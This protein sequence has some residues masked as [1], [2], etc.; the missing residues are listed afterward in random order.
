[1]KSVSPKSAAKTKPHGPSKVGKHREEAVASENAKSDELAFAKAETEKP[2]PREDAD[3]AEGTAFKSYLEAVAEGDDS[4]E[5][6]L[7]PLILVGGALALGG[8]GAVALGGGGNKAP[9][10]VT[11]VAVAATEDTA[12]TFSISATD[13]DNDVLTYTASGA[14]KGTVTGGTGGNF[15][16]TP[17][18]N[19]NGTDTVTVTVSDG[20]K[21]ATATVN[22]TIAAVNDAPTLAAIAALTTNE[23]TAKTFTA[24][25]ADI[26]STTLTYTAAGATKGVVTGGANGAFTYTPNA[27]ANGTDTFTVT[28]SDGA[29]TATQ[30]VT[31]NITPVPDAPVV[32][33][34]Q[35]VSTNEDV[36]KAITVTATDPDGDV[37]TYTAG[38]AGHG[39]VTGGGANGAFTYIPTA[40]FHGTDTFV[41]TVSDGA[42][43]ATQTVTVTVASVIDENVSI[44]LLEGATVQ[45]EDA[46][47]VGFTL[48]DNF[49]Y[50]DDS[51][52]ATNAV[53]TNFAAGDTIVVTGA[54]TDYNFT[55]IGND[56]EITY[57]NT[58][59][60][61][62]NVILLKN[63]G[64][65]AGFVGDEATA[66]AL[67]GHNFF[68]AQTA[69]TVGGDG[70][71]VAGGNLDD[72]ND[73][74]INTVAVTSAASG[75]VAY[76]EN[77]AIANSVLIQS[78]TTG[79]TI[80]VS[81]API[82]A[83]SF[84]S[85]GNDVVISYLNGATTNEIVLAGVATGVTTLID[86]IDDVEA[87]VGAGFFKAAAGGGG[88]STPTT[89][90]NIDVG[91]LGNPAVKDAG[92]G[93]IKFVDHKAV[94]SE[95]KITN[96][97]TNDLIQTDASLGDYSFTTPDD[98]D[99]EITFTYTP[100]GSTEAITNTI[101]LDEVLVGHDLSAGIY[102]YATA[103]IAVGFDFMTFG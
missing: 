85:N 99:L 50:I 13:K 22:I 79:D 42:L 32:A 101:V 68:T 61:A 63:V 28:V 80:T 51:T 20:K 3:M 6:G 30:T 96:F 15:T 48:G 65:S 7:S 19:A 43:T 40:N 100:A 31:V 58:Q 67:L 62:L 27:N 12:K 78:F 76:T 23:D 1:M 34:T 57:N 36:S 35:A 90:D 29:L 71:A 53:I 102:D 55:G 47:G 60:G 38:A 97:G 18:A 49:H 41:V 10:V 16:Y 4:D 82:S 5:G 75:N 91:V 46:G 45:N 94:A 93:S 66:E 25:G 17:N 69:P 92:T 2:A 26:D 98:H 73:D 59:S 77:A 14:T 33:A 39:T 44:D 84:T 95:V 37:L 103:K 56:I 11:P 88:G 89:S 81:G 74:N 72:D 9:V 54:A 52:K 87:L 64:A 86:S 70:V 8:I 21:S 83:Y 24:V